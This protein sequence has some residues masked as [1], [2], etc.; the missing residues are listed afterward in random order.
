MNRG[1]GDCFLSEVS[2][3]SGPFFSDEMGVML[4][5]MVIKRRFRRGKSHSKPWAPARYP[6]QSL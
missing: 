4:C 1:S 5:G 2:P 3:Y 6:K